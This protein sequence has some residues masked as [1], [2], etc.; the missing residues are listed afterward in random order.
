M[1]TK[2]RH[3]VF[4]TNSSSSHSISISLD[5]DCLMYTMIPDEDGNIVLGGGDFGWEIESYNDAWTKANY[6]AVDNRNN[7]DKLEMLKEVVKEQTGAKDVLITFDD[8]DYGIDHN[9]IQT[10]Y[11]AFASKEILR[12]FIFNKNSIL[13]TDNDNH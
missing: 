1:I 2:I 10:S 11:D 3:G 8:T 5:S 13:Y 4:E 12:Q 6:C 9:S 7:D